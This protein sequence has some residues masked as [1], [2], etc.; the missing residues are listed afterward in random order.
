MNPI[1]ELLRCVGSWMVMT[2]HYSHLITAE[3]GVLTFLW[4]GVNLF[5]VISGYVFGNL[6]FHRKENLF[7]YFLKRF[8]RIYPLYIASLL[9]YFFLLPDS[10]SKNIYFLRHLFFLNTTFSLQEAYFFNP[11]YWSLPVEVEF[12][13]LIPLLIRLREKFGI[14]IIYYLFLFSLFLK[15]FM[16]F[17]SAEL[18]SVNIF[19]IMGVHILCMFPEFGI[20]FLLF[21]FTEGGQRSFKYDSIVWLCVGSC[22]LIG[23]ARFFIDSGASGLYDNIVMRAYFSTF[24]SLGYAFILLAAVRFYENIRAFDKIFFQLGALSY[25]L[26]LFH[27]AI[28]HVLSRY[29]FSTVGIRGYITA[30]ACSILVAII[31]SRIIELPFRDY[32]R[33]RARALQSKNKVTTSTAKRNG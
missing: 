23:C 15:F 4:T 8:F 25:G 22:I 17:N 32:G 3:K 31:S 5:F 9:C 12:Y 16:A 21:R 10:A 18:P 33:S 6:I 24:C 20:G 2:C 7:P 29:N 19:N 26:Y 13:I 11:A 30:A 28:L 27:N 1:I 14:R